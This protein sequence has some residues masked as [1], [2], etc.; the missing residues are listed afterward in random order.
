MIYTS[1]TKKTEKLSVKKQ[2]HQHA[3]NNHTYSYLQHK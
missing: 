2:N 1:T 3:L